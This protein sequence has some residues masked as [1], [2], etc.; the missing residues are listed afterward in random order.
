MEMALLAGQDPQVWPGKAADAARP[1]RVRVA[2]P[3]TEK[4]VAFALVSPPS[5][6]LAPLPDQDRGALWK[7]ASWLELQLAV[8]S[9]V[10]LT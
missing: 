10:R 7:L 9:G 5:D 4:L 1:G 6:Q 3:L 8:V 2:P